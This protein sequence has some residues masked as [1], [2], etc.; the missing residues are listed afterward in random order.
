MGRR[1]TNA[2]I[3]KQTEQLPHAQICHKVGNGQVRGEKKCVITV[4]MQTMELK[5]GNS[6]I[7]VCFHQ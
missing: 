2:E 4:K 5:P 6:D 7:T 1:E 3:G